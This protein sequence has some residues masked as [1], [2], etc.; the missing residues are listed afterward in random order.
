MP[1]VREV[2]AELRAHGRILVTQRGEPVDPL[3]AHGPIRVAFPP[4]SVPI[5][6][7]G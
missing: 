7:A 3:A 4:S 2:A 5:S 6:G 1:G